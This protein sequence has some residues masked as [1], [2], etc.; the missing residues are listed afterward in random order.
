MPGY[1]SATLR[2]WL[3]ACVESIDERS[4]ELVCFK[5]GGES[6]VYVYKFCVI[7]T[8]VRF[9][10]VFPIIYIV[11]TLFVVNNDNEPIHNVWGKFPK[12]GKKQYEKKEC[13]QYGC[14]CRKADSA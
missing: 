11:F 1:N 5:G 8:F 2:S 7:I 10:A 4:E 6:I 14:F 12:R 9:C 3:V 13:C